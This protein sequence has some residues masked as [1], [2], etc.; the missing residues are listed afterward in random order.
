MAEVIQVQ[1]EGIMVTIKFPLQELVLLKQALDIVEIR[2]RSEIEDQKK[3]AEYIT[4]SFYPL[5]K[6]IVE[7]LTHGS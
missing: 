1:P 7:D 3:A 4:G 5:I 2:P 6:D